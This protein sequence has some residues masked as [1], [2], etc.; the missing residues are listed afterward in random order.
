[1]LTFL[2]HDTIRALDADT[3]SRPSERR[4]QRALAREVCSM[5]HGEPKTE[6]AE[7]AGAALFSEEIAD[8][9]ERTLLEVFAE[10]PTTTLPRTA[11][12]R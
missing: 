7:K 1:M 5:V 11:P 9:D 10:V 4:A 2:D 3:E 12:R 6:R 8:L